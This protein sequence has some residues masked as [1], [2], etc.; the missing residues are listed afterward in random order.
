MLYLRML[1]SVDGT[2][3]YGQAIRW[4]Y[5]L[6]HFGKEPNA[7]RKLNRLDKRNFKKWQKVHD[8]GFTDYLSVVRV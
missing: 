4:L 5:L 3:E 1:F 2:A 8:K 6:G 7:E